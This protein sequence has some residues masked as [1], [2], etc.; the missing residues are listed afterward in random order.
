MSKNSAER[1]PRTDPKPGDVLR[2]LPFVLTVTRFERRVFYRLSHP[3]A[4][5]V[6]AIP[7]DCNQTLKRWREVVK[8]AEVLHAAE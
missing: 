6:N 7:M 8:N 3:G 5:G 2:D 1:D 4:R